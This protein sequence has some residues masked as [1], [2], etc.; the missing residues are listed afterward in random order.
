MA[1]TNINDL[2]DE[3][4]VEI[5]EYLPL[6]EVVTNTAETSLEWRDII[7]RFIMRP[8]ILRL[9]GDNEKFKRNIMDQGWTEEQIS[10]D[11]ILSFYQKYELFSSEY[12]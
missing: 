9:A 5:F 10:T 3:M 8:R 12:M 6:D 7:A 1:G 4:L 11:L 2:P